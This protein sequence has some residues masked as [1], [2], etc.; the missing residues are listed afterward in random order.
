MLLFLYLRR[1]LASLWAGVGGPR[2]FFDRVEFFADVFQKTM[3]QDAFVIRAHRGAHRH[4]VILNVIKAWGLA[5][6]R[7]LYDSVRG[8]QGFHQTYL[9]CK[10]PF[11][12]LVHFASL[13]ARS[14][15]RHGPLVLCLTGGKA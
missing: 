12:R 15:K 4:H 1:A 2:L 5:I 14:S 11:K 10:R 9:R 8:F 3:D 13:P 6:R 7:A